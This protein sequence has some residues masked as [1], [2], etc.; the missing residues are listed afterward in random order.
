MKGDN[1]LRAEHQLTLRNSG[2]APNLVGDLQREVWG[3]I[4][5]SSTKEKW[6]TFQLNQAADVLLGQERPVQ[7]SDSG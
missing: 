4:A 6:S 3:L 2:V 5:T 7:M 1:Q